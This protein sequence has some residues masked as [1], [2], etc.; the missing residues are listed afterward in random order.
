[1]AYQVDWTELANS[2]LESIVTYIAEDNPDAARTLGLGIIETVE[3]AADFP[4]SGRIVAEKQNPLIR[5]KL[6]RT[7]YRVVYRLDEE[8]GMLSVARIR[9]T[10]Q[11]TLDLE[12]VE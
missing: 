9:N 3:N 7:N 4:F 2:D 10:S 5:E 6:V 12:V 1:M 8:N 11:G